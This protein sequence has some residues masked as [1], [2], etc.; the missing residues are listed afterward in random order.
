MSSNKT[1]IGKI[2]IL[3]NITS[4]HQDGLLSP[5]RVSLDYHHISLQE[6]L[7]KLETSGDSNIIYVILIILLLCVMMLFL[8]SCYLHQLFNKSQVRYNSL[9]LNTR[10]V[11]NNEEESVAIV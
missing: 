1:R 3:L 6:C 4:V 2:P 10:T 5:P 11:K 7:E 9:I 8:Y